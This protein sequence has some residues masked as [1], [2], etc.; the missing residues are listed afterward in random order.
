[1]RTRG[2]RLRTEQM[3]AVVCGK[4]REEVLRV[5]IGGDR[6][7]QAQHGVQGGNMVPVPAREPWGAMQGHPLP[8]QHKGEGSASLTL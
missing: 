5:I 7:K 1:M 4:P 8:A 3:L 6:D 2:G